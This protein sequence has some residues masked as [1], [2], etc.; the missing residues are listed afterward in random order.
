MLSM[1][2]NT[3][4][5]L[6]QERNINNLCPGFGSQIVLFME[7]LLERGIGPGTT[8][9]YCSELRPFLEYIENVCRITD[10][11]DLTGSDVAAYAA[12]VSVDYESGEQTFTNALNANGLLSAVRMFCL[13]LYTAGMIPDDYSLLVPGIPFSDKVNP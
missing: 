8:V 6:R 9:T 11:D 3:T 13:Y 10:V 2:M 4:S 1:K 12:T 7:S 5:P